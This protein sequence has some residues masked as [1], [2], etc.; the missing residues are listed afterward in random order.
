MLDPIGQLLN[1]LNKLCANLKQDTREKSAADGLQQSL[2]SK[3]L[4]MSVHCYILSV[5]IISCLSTRLRKQIT[6]ARSAHDRDAIARVDGHRSALRSDL[7]IGDLLRQVDPFVHGLCSACITLKIG[8][9][10]V[11]EVEIVLGLSYDEGVACC[12][13]HVVV[14]TSPRLV[15]PNY[16]LTSLVP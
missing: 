9:R 1:V 11:R 5:R 16:D 7:A 12:V 6:N 10:A 15:D 14:S 8:L 3:T 2:Q 13:S 4:M